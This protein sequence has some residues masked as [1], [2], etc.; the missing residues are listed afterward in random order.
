V[1]LQA[2]ADT[3]NAYDVVIVQHE[4]G[5]YGGQDGDQVLAILDE[6]RV[7]VIVVA[8]TVLAAPTDH[9]RT[10]SSRLRARP[11]PSSR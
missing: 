5:I 4:Y 1:G 9:Q 7:P 3:L 10:F 8:H 2:V 6:L 11:M